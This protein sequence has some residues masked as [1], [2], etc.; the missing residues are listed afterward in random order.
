MV[1]GF[2]QQSHLDHLDNMDEDHVKKRE[3]LNWGDKTVIGPSW[4]RNTRLSRMV[5]GPVSGCILRRQPMTS[6]IE[7]PKPSSVGVVGGALSANC[8][9]LRHWASR[10]RIYD[11]MIG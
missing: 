5:D 8:I 2:I 4:T 11:P 10:L 3:M 6:R 1:W 7:A 9:R